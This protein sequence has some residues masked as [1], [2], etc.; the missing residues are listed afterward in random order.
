MNNY[1]IYLKKR[2]NKPYCN[3]RKENI[4]LAECRNCS[5]K[6]YRTKVEENSFYK[7]KKSTY[8]SK[9]VNDTIRMY[10]KRNIT[11]YKNVHRYLLLSAFLLYI[12]TYLHYKINTTKE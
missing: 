2:K 11:M 7:Q 8:N 1:C 4:E 5:N 10:K 12:N 3:L 6:E 9:S